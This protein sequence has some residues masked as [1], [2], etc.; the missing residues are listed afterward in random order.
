[1]KF[2]DESPPCLSPASQTSIM[3]FR[4]GLGRGWFLEL[5]S[6]ILCLDL[7]W[8]IPYKERVILILS[9]TER[10]L[11]CIFE[12]CEVDGIWD[13]ILRNIW[14]VEELKL[15][16]FWWD[17]TLRLKVRLII[18]KQ[19]KINLK[20]FLIGFPFVAFYPVLFRIYNKIRPMWERVY[21]RTHVLYV[22]VIPRLWRNVILVL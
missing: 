5:D 4:G 1:M 20:T 3:W 21:V 8:E 16:E 15:D 14:T 2:E 22:T 9:E 11:I 12:N 13:L 17:L 7:C 19:S 10:R 6:P 18:L